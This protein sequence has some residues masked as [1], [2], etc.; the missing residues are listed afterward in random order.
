[1][2]KSRSPQRLFAFCLSALLWSKNG[3]R[4]SALRSR[5]R[6]NH[7]STR[8]LLIQKKLTFPTGWW[9]WWWWWSIVATVAAAE[10]DVAASEAVDEVS[11]A[12]SFGG[13]DTNGDGNSEATKG[14][15][16]W[17]DS[18][19]NSSIGSCNKRCGKYNLD[20]TVFVLDTKNVFVSL[21]AGIL[22]LRTKNAYDKDFQLS[23]VRLLGPTLASFKGSVIFVPASKFGKMD[24]IIYPPKFCK[25]FPFWQCL[26][27]MLIIWL[28]LLYFT[29]QCLKSNKRTHL[30]SIS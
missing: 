27:L 15:A 5:G 3:L 21:F 14:S 18:I 23:K 13:L 9:W 26:A 24:G 11:S 29:A 20:V 10:A 2:M 4:S 19:L 30:K 25:L 28:S 1:M 17:N 22:R 7:I 6:M 12:N 16:G 8:R